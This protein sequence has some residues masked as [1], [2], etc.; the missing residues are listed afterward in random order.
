MDIIFGVGRSIARRSL[1]RVIDSMGGK[2]YESSIN[3]IGVVGDGEGH[4]YLREVPRHFSIYYLELS[5][6]ARKPQR[7]RFEDVYDYLPE[8]RKKEGEWYENEVEEIVER[9]GYGTYLPAPPLALSE[10]TD[11]KSGLRIY[12][13][14]CPNCDVISTNVNNVTSIKIDKSKYEN[15]F[16]DVNHPFEYSD[17]VIENTQKLLK[18]SVEVLFSPYFT[19]GYRDVR[20]GA[21]N[22]KDPVMRF[23]CS[24]C[25]EESQLVFSMCDCSGNKR[26]YVPASRKVIDNAGR[27]C[28]QCDSDLSITGTSWL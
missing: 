25:H 18:C 27:Y 11:T 6:K 4:L 17:S 23:I 7:V 28:T 3:K 15:I 24:N 19:D 22:E 8:K 2:G 14:K 5:E 16:D 26:G 9:R 13:Y 21:V 12:K 20:S 10:P 1:K